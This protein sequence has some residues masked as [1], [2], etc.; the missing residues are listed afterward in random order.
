MT[1][2]VRSY[3]KYLLDQSA[4]TEKVDT[5]IRPIIL[6]SGDG[7]KESIALLSVSKRPT[8]HLE[9]SSGHTFT[10]MQVKCFDTELINANDLRELVRGVSQGYRGPFPDGVWVEGISADNAQDLH[11]R[12]V[13]G[14]G[15]G[16]MV[17]IID[18]EIGHTEAVP[19]YA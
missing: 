17:A 2:I 16:R 19:V 11:E 12:P 18:F 8:E 14:K 5:R 15:Q 3:R 6:G 1:N 4:I 7:G 10:R 13:D 9:G